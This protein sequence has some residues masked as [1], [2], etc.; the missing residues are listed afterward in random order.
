VLDVRYVWVLSVK[1]EWLACHIYSAA[2]AILA[3]Y[4]SSTNAC[5]SISIPPAA[6]G[7]C[8]EFVI[9][10]QSNKLGKQAFLDQKRTLYISTGRGL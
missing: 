10:R 9:N 1:E 8:I 7:I 3:T 4:D 6:N 5:A 2:Q